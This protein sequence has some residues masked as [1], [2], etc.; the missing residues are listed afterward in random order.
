MITRAGHLRLGLAV[1][2]TARETMS[3]TPGLVYDLL[4]Q[5]KQ[6]RGIKAEV[7]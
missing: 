4:E 7:D 1:G 3:E 6:E 5:L 2:L